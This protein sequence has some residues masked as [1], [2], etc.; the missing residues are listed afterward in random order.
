SGQHDQGRQH[1][2]NKAISK[3]LQRI[4]MARGLAMSEAQPRMIGDLAGKMLKI[5]CCGGKVAAEMPADQAIEKEGHAVDNQNPGESKMPW[6][7]NGKPVGT[8]QGRPGWK[9]AN[10]GLSIHAGKAQPSSGVK[11]FSEDPGHTL[12]RIAVII[13]RRIGGENGMLEVRAVA[14][15]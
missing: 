10:R 7:G 12:D 11:R 14:E 8:G 2:Q 9:S 6:P 3:F 13:R 4:V 15:I 1:E 5:G